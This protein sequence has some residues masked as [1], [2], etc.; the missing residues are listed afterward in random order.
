METIDTRR[1][2]RFCLDVEWVGPGP[3]RAARDLQACHRAGYRP[4][5]PEWSDA[6]LIALHRA[7][8]AADPTR[9]GRL[10]FTESTPKAGG[11]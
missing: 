11:P 2:F 10:G 8:A 6:S 1:L 9:S 4:D 3:R 7:D 5:Q